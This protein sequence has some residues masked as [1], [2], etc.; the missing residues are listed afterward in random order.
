MFVLVVSLPHRMY[1]ILY[2]SYFWCDI[3]H[4]ITD[5]VELYKNIQYLFYFD[6]CCALQHPAEGAISPVT[7]HQKRV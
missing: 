5:R 4:H 1:L 7:A 3:F 2:T 6:F